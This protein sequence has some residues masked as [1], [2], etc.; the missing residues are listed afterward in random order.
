[1]C[2][3]VQVAGGL[4]PYQTDLRP[5]AVRMNPERGH[6]NGDKDGERSKMM[7]MKGTSAVRQVDRDRLQA[8]MKVVLA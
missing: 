6:V 2:L 7:S 3:C 5:L 4:H 1:M 8:T